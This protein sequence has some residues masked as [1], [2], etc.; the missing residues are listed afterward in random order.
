M[1]ITE[2]KLNWM[3]DYVNIDK[4]KLHQ[5]L[6]LMGKKYINDKGLKQLWSEDRPTTSYCY[7]VSEMVYRFYP[8]EN[9][10]PMLIRIPNYEFTHRYLLYPN[11]VVIDLTV[12]QFDN[13][14]LIDYQQGKSQ[15][16]M[17]TKLNQPSKR[18]Q[19]L[20]ELY[21]SKL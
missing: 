17:V 18:A 16:F 9:V 2:E 8:Q 14:E 20:F 15:P 13:Y 7:V 4:N 10:K 19:I 5:C 6:K 12:D 11:N 1:R 3:F 21:N